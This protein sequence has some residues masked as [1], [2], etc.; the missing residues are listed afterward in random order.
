MVVNNQQGQLLPNN[1]NQLKTW[2]VRPPP[3]QLGVAN[4]LSKM[5]SLGKFKPSLAIS[6]LRKS[7]SES[8]ISQKYDGLG[9]FD[10][11]N[12][13]LGVSDFEISPMA[14]D[15]Q[16]FIRKLIRNEKLRNLPL[17]E[18]AF[19]IVLKDI[20]NSNFHLLYRGNHTSK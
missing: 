6:A 8:R 10:F 15:F 2:L 5:L 11:E 13:D 9:V 18:S 7:V 3:W 20:G 4:G 17:P 12:L 19:K 16:F 1:A 14:G